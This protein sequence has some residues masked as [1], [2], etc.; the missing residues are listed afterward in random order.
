MVRKLLLLLC[1]AFVV[2][3]Y[4]YPCVVLPVGTYNGQISETETRS[5]KFGWGGMVDIT[6]KVKTKKK[7]KRLL[8]QSHNI[9]NLRATEYLFA[10]MKNLK[11]ALKSFKFALSIK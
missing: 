1:I 10:K 8:S 7:S 5:Y 9:T 3:G 6:S 4:A 2:I 11:K